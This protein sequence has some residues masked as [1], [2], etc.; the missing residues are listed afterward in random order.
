MVLLCNFASSNIIWL[1]WADQNCTPYVKGLCPK[2]LEQ[3]SRPNSSARRRMMHHLE[4]Y[5]ATC[6]A[7]PPSVLHSFP[8]PLAPTPANVC[9]RVAFSPSPCSLLGCEESAFAVGRSLSPPPPV[10]PPRASPPEGGSLNGNTALSLLQHHLQL[11]QG[12]PRQYPESPSM[13]RCPWLGL[14]PTLWGRSDYWDLTTGVEKME[15]AEVIL[16]WTEFLTSIIDGIKDAKSCESEM[17]SYEKDKAVDAELESEMWQ[18]MEDDDQAQAQ[19]KPDCQKCVFEAGAIPMKSVG[20][21]QL[22]SAL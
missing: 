16:C 17:L 10:T 20:T 9:L 2:A 21:D 18:R 15:R 5:W 11:P 3:L 14:G 1:S 12:T 22:S 4:A 7:A 13:S 6:I 19:S 8:A